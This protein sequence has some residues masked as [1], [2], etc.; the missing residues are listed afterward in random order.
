MFG[1]LLGFFRPQQIAKAAPN[2]G[3][4]PFGFGRPIYSRR[5]DARPGNYRLISKSTGE[6]EYYGTTNNL[7]RRLGEHKRSGLYD[8]DRHHFAFQLAKDG[9]SS[10]VLYEHERKKIKRHRPQLNRRDGGA[11]PRW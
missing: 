6:L 10:D 3:G 11:G 1:R 5:P 8:P 4:A 9:V 7:S 2:E